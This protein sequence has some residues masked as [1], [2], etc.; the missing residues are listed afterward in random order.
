MS[1]FGDTS[2]F[3]PLL[4]RTEADHERVRAAF[5]ALLESARPIW[6]TSFVLLETMALLQHRIGLEA[7]RDFDEDIL[8]VLH[9]HWVEQD[10]FRRGV[11]RL[12]R[13][14]RRRLSLVDC[15]AFECMLLQGLRTAFALDP[16]FADAGFELLPSPA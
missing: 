3:Y 6:T 2:A 14:D 15:V 16:H 4:V 7:A 1:V 12:W 5:A 11:D 8:P 9:V 13:A 10:L